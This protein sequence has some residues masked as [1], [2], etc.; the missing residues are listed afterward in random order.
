MRTLLPLFIGFLAAIFIGGSHPLAARAAQS[1]DQGDG[2]VVGSIEIVIDGEARAFQVREGP[3]DEGFAT[4]YSQ[5]PVGESMVFGVSLMGTEESSDA[6][7]LVQTGVYQS[8]MEQVCDPFSNN[9]E[10]HGSDRGGRLRPGEGNS[11]TCPDS[12]VDI[13]VTEASFDEETEVLHLLGTFSGSLGRG[14]DASQVTEGRFEATLRS[15]Q[16]L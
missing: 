9:V 8:S 2:A 16:V 1:G 7:I 4:G 3:V 15:F 13:N 11:T 12:P 5:N 10:M 14:A 6:R